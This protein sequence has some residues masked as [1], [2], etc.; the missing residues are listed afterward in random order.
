[1]GLMAPNLLGNNVTYGQLFALR[2][3]FLQSETD[4]RRDFEHLLHIGRWTY[5]VSLILRITLFYGW[6]SWS[7]ELLGPRCWDSNQGSRR[8]YRALPQGY[9]EQWVNK[10][11]WKDSSSRVFFANVRYNYFFYKTHFELLPHILSVQWAIYFFPKASCTLMNT[12]IHI[13]PFAQI[14]FPLLSTR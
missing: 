13:F 2:L 11:V 8:F 9:C 12:S 14:P 3:K 10:Y 6:E 4:G 1:M 7:W 5:F